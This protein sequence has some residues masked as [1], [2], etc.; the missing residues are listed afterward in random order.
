METGFGMDPEWDGEWGDGYLHFSWLNYYPTA[1]AKVHVPSIGWLPVDWVAGYRPGG[2]RT[3][4]GAITQADILKPNFCLYYINIHS[5][6]IT[7][8]KEIFL[9]WN[10]GMF[11]TLYD[12]DVLDVNVTL[13]QVEY[14]RAIGPQSVVVLT[15][16]FSDEKPEY[17]PGVSQI[18]KVIFGMVNDY[19]KEV[20]YG[21]MFFEGYV[22]KKFYQIGSMDYYKRKGSPWGGQNVHIVADAILA[23]DREVDYSAYRH[24][25]VSLITPW[26]FGWWISCPEVYMYPY[27]DLRVETNDGVTVESAILLQ[28]LTTGIPGWVNVRHFN[29]WLKVLGMKFG[30]P[31]ERPYAGGLAPYISDVGQVTPSIGPVPNH[32]LGYHMLAWEK[33]TLGWIPPEKIAEIPLGTTTRVVLDP[34]EQNTTGTLAVKI[35]KTPV[36][37]WLV[38]ARRPIGYDSYLPLI[39]APDT[40]VEAIGHPPIEGVLI[41]H[42][43]HP[44]W[45]GPPAWLGLRI[46][47]SQLL[48]PDNTAIFVDERQNLLIAVIEEV[49]LS[50]VIEITT[51]DRATEIR[52]LIE[53][54]ARFTVTDLSISPTEVEVGK[55]VAIAVKVTNTGELSGSYTVDL[56]VAGAK[57]DTK[58]VTLAA[59]ESATV[60]FEL[61]KEEAGTFDIE[62]A[63]L[64]G[65]FN[66]LAPRQAEFVATDLSI[67]P[68]EVEAG[69]AVAIA[70][71][72]TN[73]GELSGSYTVDLKV[74]G[75]KVDT[76]TVTLAA[77]ESATVTFELVKEEA[78]T[79]DIE[80]AGL[81]GTFSVKEMPPPPLP[82]RL[83]A[84]I[85]AVAIAAIGV[86]IITYR[87]RQT[88]AHKV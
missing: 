72:V 38:E 57:V 26:K 88:S 18:E 17:Y 40:P 70:V 22:T 36:S 16:E 27:D 80:V 1:W 33:I 66:V 63:G 48:E 73:T 82:W 54:R 79:F 31:D 81:K 42:V 65:T 20:S 32:I 13:N 29:M 46:Y 9:G 11:R 56:K 74:A 44:A 76:K 41:T 30:L 69:K 10:E 64:K 68:T 39:A 4:K 7:A 45:A 55:A 37:Y 23:A 47:T 83:Y 52:K 21:Q 84:I 61:V 51:A 15:V 71:K 12:R 19:Y 62:V 78:G 35:V 87:R 24:V 49:G 8:R 67:S 60:T 2:P 43:T 34:I 3:P 14:P 59:G 50:Y 58:A 25:I 77:G 5:D 86:A 85:A 6:P 53:Q 28:G 75:V